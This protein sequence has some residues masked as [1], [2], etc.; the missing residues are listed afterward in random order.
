MLCIH[1][2]KHLFPAIGRGKAVHDAEQSALLVPVFPNCIRPAA[3]QMRL[4]IRTSIRRHREDGFPRHLLFIAR[5]RGYPWF[6]W[7]RRRGLGLGLRRGVRQSRTVL[8]LPVW[9]IRQRNAQHGRQ[10]RARLTLG[11]P[12]NECVQRNQ[13]AASVS[14]RR[15]V[16]PAPGLLADQANAHRPSSLTIA[17]ADAI[18][19]TFT[20]AIGQPVRQQ[21]INLGKRSRFDA[22]EIVKYHAAAFVS[23]DLYGTSVPP[24]TDGWLR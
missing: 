22:P 21:R 14:I 20:H 23:L 5:V 6:G 3:N 2:R 15:E 17:G 12:V 9:I 11:N 18:L 7:R 1:A 4:R 19:R 10:L 16:C 24:I 8:R 13:A